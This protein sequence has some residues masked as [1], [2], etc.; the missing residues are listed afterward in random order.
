MLRQLPA[1]HAARPAAA[2][3]RPARPRPCAPRAALS[4]YEY[5][6]D[7]G[8]QF[9][10][11]LLEPEAPL[12][13]SAWQTSRLQEEL[14][15]GRRRFNVTQ[16]SR[17]L[18]LER[19]ELIGWLKLNARTAPRAE[20]P[21][22][23]PPPPQPLSRQY[24]SRNGPES[25]P[26]AFVSTVGKVVDAESAGAAA[27]EAALL[28]LRGPALPARSGRSKEE[29]DASL[30]RGVAFWKTF[31]K[32][33]LGRDQRDTLEMVYAQTRFPNDQIIDGMYDAVRLQRDEVI[34]WF[35]ER[36]TADTIAAEE[37]RAAR[38]EEPRAG[39]GGRG[40][41]RGGRGGD[42]GLDGE[43]RA[44]GRGGRGGG[45]WD[46]TPREGRERRPERPPRLWG[47]VPKD[48]APAPAWPGTRGPRKRN[49]DFGPR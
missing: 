33:R 6:E 4:D 37:A 31:R 43:Q 8:Q 38:G 30:P 40:G 15:L 12:V 46:A 19:S 29:F 23:P 28:R 21:P 10:G 20:P 48:A 2:S 1:P 27:A 47:G 39:R 26:S 44:G 34:A 14:A 5:D 45:R 36:R 7:A 3:R 42:S 11:S 17:E 49:E 24:A 41:G 35:R 22:P 18:Q 13:L 16:L 32:T 25:P 9:L